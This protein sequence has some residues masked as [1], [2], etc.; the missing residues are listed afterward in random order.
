MPLPFVLPLMYAYPRVNLCEYS[1]RE[2]YGVSKNGAKALEYCL[3][4]LEL[5]V[6]VKEREHIYS[7][8]FRI[9][10]NNSVV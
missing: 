9:I 6:G 2:G 1:Y 8:T 10:K 7:S 5:C 4:A 3:K